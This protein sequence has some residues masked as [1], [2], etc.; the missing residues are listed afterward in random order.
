LIKWVWG[1]RWVGEK[2]GLGK[3]RVRGGRWV[4]R[5]WIRKMRWVWGWRW[6]GEGDGLGGRGL[7]E[8]D[9]VTKAG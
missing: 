5:I 7:G 8:G 1:W 4:W 9:C 2:D 3:K 6:V